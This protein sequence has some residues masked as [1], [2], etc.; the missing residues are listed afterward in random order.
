MLNNHF[1]VAFRYLKNHL[2]FTIINILGLTLGFFCFFLL[3]TYVLKE[4]SFDKNQK[5]VYRLLQKTTDEN[6]TLRELAQSPPKVGIESKMRF[7][8][9][10]QQTQ[11]LFLGRTNVGNEPASVTHQG[12]AALD[13]NFLQVFN[14]PLLE[15]TSKELSTRPKGII[16]T[17]S[18]R[19]LYFG[20]EPALGKLLMLGGLQ[21]PVVGVLEDFP[22]NTHLEDM[23]F[24]THLMASEMYGWFNEFIASNWSNN[25]MITYFKMVPDADLDKLGEKIT[26]LTKENYPKDQL[27][28]STFAIQAV[29]DIHLYKNEVEGEMNKNKGNA[30]YVNLFFLIGMLILL[31]ACFNYAGL[32]NIAFIDRF[33]EIALRQIVGAGKAHLLRQFLAESLLVISVSLALAYFFLWILQPL[34]QKWFSTTMNLT[35]VPLT[36]MLL[37]LS[38]GLILGL[39]SVAY[40]FWAIIRTGISSSLKN[41][42]SGGSKLPFRRVMLTFQFV[43]VITFLTASLL[44]NR[45][46]K[47]L[48]QRE[49]GFEKEGLATV[50]INSRI[51]RTQ[52]KAIKTEFLRLPEVAAI[53]VSSRVPGEWKNIPL[54]KVKRN[55]QANREAKDMLF[56]GIDRDFIKTYDITILQGANFTDTPSDSTKVLIN[57][58]AALALGLDNP[59]GQYI[60]VPYVNFG[61][62]TEPLKEPFKVQIT[63][64]VEDFQIEDFR[65]E[66]K[67]LLLANWN[68]PVH[69]IDYYTMRIKT[70]NWSQTLAALQQ[71]NDAFDSGAPMELN[72][73]DDKFSRFF[74]KDREHF[75]LLNFFSVIV[76]F[77]AC[78]G[79]F[80]T[81]AFIARSRTKEIGIRK[82]L[83]SSIPEL[84]VLLSKDF[85]RLVLLGFLIAAPITWFLLSRW[86]SGFAYR[87]DFA[88]WTIVVAG[89][90]CLSLTLLTVGYQ[91][92]KTARINPANSLRTE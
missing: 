65:T 49:L 4:T 32:L 75:K 83:G 35:Q 6:G 28:N 74:E 23:V 76:V 36:G 72:I 20:G 13:D 64:V 56:L 21:Y 38:V 2:A 68:N 41:T 11:I 53:S 60:E 3:N 29:Q 18:T 40:P 62:S 34:V 58:T 37:V 47:F 80:A 9:I 86:L 31:V 16:L 17:R 88:W 46:M 54:A 51:L 77:L 71:V 1:T 50:D 57:R 39:L 5:H 84:L 33:K 63:G 10:E 24:I 15:G 87:I 70:A 42:V 81:S 59:I 61:G 14:F 91:S 48:E 30:L 8:E 27:F 78:M 69:S 12:I 92:L 67:P 7:D 52:F 44:F 45:Q 89:V 79:L 82:V 90:A 55:G 66:I 26:A 85:V 25:E 22:E 43:A 73:L 19:E